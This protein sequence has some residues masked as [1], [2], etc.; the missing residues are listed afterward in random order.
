[1]ADPRDVLS[2]CRI[3]AAACGITVSVEGEQVVRVRGD[4]DHPVSKGYTCAK[5]RGLAEWHHDPRR[6]DRPRRRGV[7]TGWADVLDD[8]GGALTS[9]IGAAGPDAV[10]LYLA[11]GM[12]Y[13]SA[14]QVAS[15]MWLGSIGSRSFYTAATV[16]NAP[17]LV[18]AELVTGNAMLS[19]VWDAAAGGLLLLVGTNPVVSH[20]YGT[21]IPDP[22]RH[23]RT[24]RRLGGRL[25]V[26]DPRRTEAAALAD[27]HLA[28]RP[29]ADVALLA[30]VASALLDEG[31]DE[32]EVAGWCEPADVVALRT[33]LAPFTVARASAVAGLEVA[34][35][36]RLV[37]DVRA[38][39]GR[40]AIMCGTGTTMGRDGILVEWLRWVLLIL[41]G[42][43]DRPGGMR[44][45]DGPLGRLRP[46]RA[47][48][49][50]TESVP[51]PRSRP[52]LV[53]VVGQVP[54]VALADEI[55]AGQ[56]RALVVT[57]GNP[58]SALPEPGRVRDALASLDVLAVVDVMDGEL[59]ALATHVLP[60]TGQLERADLML[61][62]NL[63]VR[64]GVQATAAVVEPVADRRPVWWML[65]E[66]SRRMGGS[67]LGGARPDDLSDETY[68]RG[69]LAH[70]PLDADAVFAAGPRGVDVAPDHG[71]VHDT[72]LPGGRWQ[73]APDVLVD[74]LAAHAADADHDSTGLVLTPRREVAWSNSVRYAGAGDEPVARLHPTDARAAGVGDGDRVD[75]VTQ[76]GA[77][78]AVVALDANGREGVVSVTH[79]RT[80]DQP[81]GGPGRLTSSRHGVDRLTGM[82]L[83]S[84][85]PVSVA[86]APPGADPA[87]AR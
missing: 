80:S 72:M 29:G 26:I 51:G 42:S 21:T 15:A 87:S 25:W 54:A 59:T 3:C 70:S 81:D 40:L 66:L 46:P 13:D 60:A 69:L 78:A 6:L 34:A 44:F 63:S 67:L 27:E 82:P 85:L 35:V 12:A 1:M 48:G 38:H 84:G 31:H 23:L 20:G 43:L 11:T 10:A 73:L 74:R 61:A 86:P 22:V 41:S 64:C 53:R 83:A 62:A 33:A 24:H 55:E 65:G 19:P 37:A 18:A 52:E 7:E 76:H 47:P 71:W 45:Q 68:L 58:I 8:L 50:R 39:R 36:E 56:V 2:F 28:V 32:E 9:I 79:S 17:V 16:D 77:M 75:L 4:A 5:G 57:G 14:G 30:A 49:S